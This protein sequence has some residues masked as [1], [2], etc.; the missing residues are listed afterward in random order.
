MIKGRKARLWKRSATVMFILTILGFGLM[1]CRLFKLQIIDGGKLKKAAVD[2]SI[3]EIKSPALRGSILDSN[4]KILAQ[5]AAAWNVILEPA[6]I[7][8]ENIS[9]IADA[10]SE[11]VDVEYSKIVDAIN[12]NRDSLYL[13]IKRKI[14]KD[15]KDKIDSLKKSGSIFSGIN[16]EPTYNRYYPYGKFCAQVLGFVDSD[17][18]GISGLEKFYDEYLKG[19]T[20]KIIMEKTG[21]DTDMPYED[22]QQNLTENGCDIV[23]TI[24][25]KIQHDTEKIL[26]ESI[27]EYKAKSGWG[28]V[29]KPDTGE[30]LSMTS[31]PDF[32]PNK[33]GELSDEKKREEINKLP[34]NEREAALSKAIQQ[35]HKNKVINEAYNPGSV[36]KIVTGSSCLQEATVNGNS[37]FFCSGALT[38][39]NYP[40]AIHCT[41][42]HGSQNFDE[43]FCNS[44]NPAFMTMGTSLGIEKFFDYFSAFGF[45]QATNIDFP[46]E[47]IGTPYQREKMTN[48]DLAIS[49]FG[50]G[51]TTTAINMITAASAAV[52]G[53]NLVQPHL[54]KQI[55]HEDGSIVKHADTSLVKRQ[56]ISEEVSKKMREVMEKNVKSGGG[57][58]AQVAGYRIGGKTGTSEKMQQQV[59]TGKG[60]YWTSFLGCVPANDPEVIALFVFDEPQGEASGGSTAAPT[61]SKVMSSILPYLNIEKTS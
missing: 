5:S 9:K 37:R 55:V 38:I 29:M 51:F 34:E 16:L 17:S 1:A 26:E 10:V 54:V 32:D 20:A 50:Q 49:A 36:F 30:I 48:V 45:T 19:K 40:E 56:V 53:G 12:T 4:G 22:S 52:N 31:K 8:D 61:F 43:A 35:Q 11:I 18:N 21:I 41:G 15:I 3:R 7:K 39:P 23:L 25:E 28:I 47:E 6:N 33:Y 59:E 58:K 14:G 46:G 24:D 2:Q 60:G 13:P 57:T 44:C 42:V 27:K